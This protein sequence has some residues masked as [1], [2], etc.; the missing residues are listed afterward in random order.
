[1]RH[2]EQRLPPGPPGAAFLSRQWSIRRRGVFALVAA[3]LGVLSAVP[4]WAESPASGS[5]SLDGGR[6][7]AASWATAIQSAYVAPTTPQGAAVPAYDPQPDLRP[8]LRAARRDGE[9]G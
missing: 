5:G 2:H 1:M 6:K 9:R 8:Q 3:T 4:A 7:W